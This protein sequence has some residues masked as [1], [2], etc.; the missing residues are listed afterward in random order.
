MLVGY[1]RVSSDGDRQVLAVI[2]PKFLHLREPFRPVFPRQNASAHWQI[3]SIG[4]ACPGA[5]ECDPI[6]G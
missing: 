4:R 5:A 1:M 3:V 2:S 6:R